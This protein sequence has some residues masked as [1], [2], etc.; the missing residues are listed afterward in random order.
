MRN[1]GILAAVLVLAA[2]AAAAE[3]GIAAASEWSPGWL[4]GSQSVNVVPRPS[5]DCSSTR[6]W[7]RSMMPN[8]IASPRPV[9][10]R[11]LVVKN[12]SKQRRRTSSLM[13][14]P[15]SATWIQAQLPTG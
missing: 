10:A 13:P 14:E 5:S 15:E 2:P 11:P 8:T 4:A 7:C 3:G 1:P 6:P 9:P 12:G